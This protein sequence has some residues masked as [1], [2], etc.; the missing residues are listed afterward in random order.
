[1]KTVIVNASPRKNWNTAMLLRE[2]EKGAKS[3]GAETEYVDLYDLDFHGCRSCLA[4]KSKKLEPC[5][6]YWK[7]DLSPLIDRILAADSF[8]LGSPIYFGQPSSAFRALA[9]RLFFCTLSYDSYG[10]CYEGKLDMGII[11][12]MNVTKEQY[13]DMTRPGLVKAEGDFK[14]LLK[15]ELTVLPCFDTQQ[16]E[17]Y[18]KYRM[19]RFDAEEKY[20]SRKERFPLDLK[21]AFDLGKELGSERK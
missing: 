20:R 18:G 1:M 2:A 3:A 12:T 13:E 5:R 7:D 16:V 14:R 21:K 10:S 11:Y 4:C 6:C 19:A 9:E 17:D 15:G 8:I